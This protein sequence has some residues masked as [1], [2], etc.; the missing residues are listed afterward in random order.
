MSGGDFNYAYQ[1]VEQF[2]LELAHKLDNPTA[3]YSTDPEVIKTLHRIGC[4]A[5]K[6]A[7]LMKEVEWLYSGDI[8]S[9]T[10]MDRVKEIEN[11]N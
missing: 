7:A 8:G 1:T 2:A 10:F 4:D 9:D 6:T 11:A 3:Y 5:I